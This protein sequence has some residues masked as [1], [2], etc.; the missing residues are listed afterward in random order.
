MKGLV[1]IL[2]LRVRSVV[3]V[4][5]PST[6][7]VLSLSVC[8]PI[9]HFP[10]SPFFFFSFPFSTSP[11][12]SFPFSFASACLSPSIAPSVGSAHHTSKH[13]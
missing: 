5:T 1:S 2:F 11:S 12:P 13:T 4:H 7:L 9:C 10:P 3:A 6:S 8:L